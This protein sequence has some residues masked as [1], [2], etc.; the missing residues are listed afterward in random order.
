MEE[1]NSYR[2]IF[3]QKKDEIHTSEE[4]L[5]AFDNSFCA[6]F[7]L[8]EDRDPTAKSRL[9]G[10]IWDIHPDAIIAEADLFVVQPEPVAA[11][12]QYLMIS[13]NGTPEINDLLAQRIEASGAITSTWYI[14]SQKQGGIKTCCQ[15]V[16]ESDKPAVI[17]KANLLIDGDNLLLSIR[18]LSTAD[19][20]RMKSDG[21]S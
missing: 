14:R 17:H 1:K 21:N 5:Q 6:C 8:V 18:H 3:R 13:K 12:G 15:Y 10:M 19:R 4:I 11:K 9:F 7:A 2:A 16:L 20:T